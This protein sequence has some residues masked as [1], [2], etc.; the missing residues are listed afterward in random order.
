MKKL[1]F[2]ATLAVLAFSC[3]KEKRECPGSIEKVFNQTGFT[4]VK[5]GDANTVSITKADDFSIKAKGCADDLA[6]LVITIEPGHILDIR[7][8]NYKNN[9]NRVDFTI[10]LPVL[11]GVIL[12]GASEGA[13]S[14][15]EDQNQVMRAVLSG[16]STGVVNGTGIDLSVDISGASKLTA[17]G[18]TETLY[19]NISGASKLEAF[20]VT[21]TE[22]DIA[23]SGNSIAR[24]TAVDKIFADASGAS[25]I[26]YKGN[27]A[28]KS[29]VTSGAG[30]IVKE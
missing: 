25:T 4:K 17:T 19:G 28:V 29:L 7:F 10:T 18:T 13:V 5:L 9:R 30:R 26:Y 15:F 20:G 22:V 11:N 14:G 1:L 2:C 3:S 21:A 27:P 24:V 23:A 8:R 6:D 12:S 16:A